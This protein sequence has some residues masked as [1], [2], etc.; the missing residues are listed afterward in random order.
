M[1]A[2]IPEV[3]GPGQRAGD[4]NR[5]DENQSIAATAPLP[6]IR[7]KGEHLQLAGHIFDTPAFDADRLVSRRG[8]HLSSSQAI[9]RQ[10]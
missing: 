7:D 6:G 3:P 1:I 9:K 2:C 5:E 4:G 10:S 8:L